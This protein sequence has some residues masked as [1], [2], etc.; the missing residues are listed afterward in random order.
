MCTTQRT[1]TQASPYLHADAILDHFLDL[2]GRDVLD[3]T[4]EM[5]K[6]DYYM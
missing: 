4:L 2:G 5:H 1:L 3:Q 6:L